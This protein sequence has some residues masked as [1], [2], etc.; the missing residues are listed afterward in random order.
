MI[1]TVIAAW[2]TGSSSEWRRKWGFWMFLVSNVL[3]IVWAYP[4]HA[5]ALIVLQLFLAG[6][7]IR[8][9]KK[10]EEVGSQ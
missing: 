7:N 2:F 4:A 5:W 6:V 10:N 8:G 9:A 3:W 1:I